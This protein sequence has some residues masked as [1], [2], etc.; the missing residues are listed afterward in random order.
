MASG[1]DLTLDFANYITGIGSA[2]LSARNSEQLRRLLLDNLGV[3][4]VGATQPWTRSLIEW[5]GRF[6]GTGQSPVVGT[7]LRVAPSIA[8]LVN[9]T[10][11]HGY[12]LDDTHDA[13]MS[14]PGAVVIPAALA[15]AAEA[16]ASH[17]TTF[18]AIAAGLG[19]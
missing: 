8:A 15:V 1:H 9:G 5:A 2:A 18:S 17:Q 7:D 19:G 3:S 12:E 10:A 13:S 11:A 4:L 14:H 6:A 16:G